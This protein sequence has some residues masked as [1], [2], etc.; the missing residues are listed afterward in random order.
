MKTAQKLSSI[1]QS[2]IFDS[3]NAVELGRLLGIL[4]EM[5]LPKHTSFFL[6]ACLLTQSFS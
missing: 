4:E 2:E 5:E 1:R 3:F 6:R